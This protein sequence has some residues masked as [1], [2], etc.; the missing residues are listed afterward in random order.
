[1]AAG[2]VNGQGSAVRE[3]GGVMDGQFAAQRACKAREVSVLFFLAKP[4]WIKVAA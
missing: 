4:N 2:P 1:M 3:E